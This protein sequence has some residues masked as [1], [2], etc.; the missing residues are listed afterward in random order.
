M[1][2]VRG[3]GRK[4]LKLRSGRLSEAGRGG[5]VDISYTVITCY[6][7]RRLSMSLQRTFNSFLL[8]LFVLGGPTMAGC[9]APEEAKAPVAPPPPG[10][11]E[12]KRDLE[13]AKKKGDPDE[14]IAVFNKYPKFAAGK[15]ALRLGVRKLLE[16]ALE[17]AEGC[18]EPAAN[19]AVA[20]VAP[21][22]SDDAEIDEAYDETKQAILR[23]HKRC[24]LV[25][26]DAD[27]KRAETD[28]DYARA[29]N[30]IVTEKDADGA[31]LKKRRV[32][33]T[34]RWLKWL[35]DT[36]VA[37][38]KKGS[39]SAVIGDKKD[40]FDGSIDPSQ[41][42]PEASAELAKRS[43]A[44]AGIRLVYE[45]LEG[46]QLLDPPVRYWT[47]GSPKARRVDSPSSTDG[48]VMANGVSFFAIAKG[49]VGGV[50][51]L[52]AGTGEG[53]LLTRL[54]SIKA[55]IVEADARTWD[56]RVTLPDQLLGARVLAP[57]APNSDL[58]TPSIVLSESKGAVV[59]QS[60]SK[61]G[62][63]VAAKRK[64]LRGVAMGP[65]LKVTVMVGNVGKPGEIA[66]AP[67]ENRVL[68]R[69]AGFESYFP[70]A[71]I[72][73]KRSDLPALPAE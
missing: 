44:I 26:L 23:E 55:V 69:V 65:G 22:T 67:E 41:L 73:I 59:V 68:V 14:L 5:G 57:V 8:S 36:L 32:E 24:L 17:S 72:R 30:R 40:A 50:T 2:P 19:G 38:T 58:L 31:A 48:T 1:T 51:V 12:A 52:A 9:P 13:R 54:G 42:P 21:Y 45:K 16:Q 37:I 33:L 25:K 20:K 18:D 6:V 7:S 70:I 39:I 29:F 62:P 10:E 43:D 60:L 46:G 3:T 47:F 11:S 15:T 71:D 28:W 49:K 53:N 56:T 61:K 35:D 27:V 4:A 66:D 64:D 34:T 63:K